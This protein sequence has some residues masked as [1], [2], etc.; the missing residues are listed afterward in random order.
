MQR[1]NL[2]LVPDDLAV[3]QN[4]IDFARKHFSHTAD[5][6]LLGKNALPHITLCQFHAP[7]ETTATA[8][9]TTWNKPVRLNVALNQLYTRSG[10]DIHAGKVWIE[11]IAVAS[12]LKQ[13]QRSCFEHLENNKMSVITKPDNYSPHLTFARLA[14]QLQALPAFSAIV[15][16][17]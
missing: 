10:S 9:F 5:K 11:L 16:P 12:E 2:A 3:S 1:F 7:S 13:L 4:L 6:Y 14:N 15:L 8:V 17:P